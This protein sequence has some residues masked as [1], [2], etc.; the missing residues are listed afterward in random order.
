MDTLINIKLGGTDEFVPFE[1]DLQKTYLPQVVLLHYQLPY[2]TVKRER[3]SDREVESIYCPLAPFQ[4][5]GSVLDSQGQRKLKS[6]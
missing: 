2:F 5:T 1:D 6:L 4:Y 3:E